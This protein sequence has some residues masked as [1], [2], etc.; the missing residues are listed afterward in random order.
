MLRDKGHMSFTIRYI[1]CY[2]DFDIIFW[3]TWDSLDVSL[4]NLFQSHWLGK[5]Y[6]KRGPEGND[7]HKTNVPHMR[8]SFRHEVTLILKR[9]IWFTFEWKC[10]HVNLDKLVSHGWQVKI[11]ADMEGGDAVCLFWKSEISWR[12]RALMRTN[13]SKILL[14]CIKLLCIWYPIP[15]RDLTKKLWWLPE[16]WL[17]TNL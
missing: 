3:W 2:K 16:G 1:I 14:I 8:I 6:Y 17:I 11:I 12:C 5:K 13:F 9:L 4:L 15:S 10:V 7:I